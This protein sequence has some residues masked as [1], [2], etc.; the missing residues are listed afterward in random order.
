MYINFVT[1][2]FTT[3][4]F[5]CKTLLSQKK[6]TTIHFYNMIILELLESTCGFSLVI[7]HIGLEKGF[8]EVFIHF[9]NFN[10]F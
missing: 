7:P 8:K 2:S 3:N 6:D 5:L 4:F 1:N 10:F 9:L